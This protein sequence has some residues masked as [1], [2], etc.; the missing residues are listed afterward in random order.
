MAIAKTQK[1]EIITIHRTEIKN[2]EY[3]P[4]FIT[5]EAEKRLKQGLKKFGLATTL[6]WNKRTG[7][8]VSGHQRLAQMDLIEGTQ[9]YELTVSCVDLSK[10][11]MALNVQMNNTSMMGEFDIDALEE[12]VNAGADLLDFGFSESDI[13]IMF[14]DSEL[15]EK[16]QDSS[17]VSEAKADLQE[18]KKN[19]KEYAERMKKENDCSYYFMVVC[20]N[21]DEKEELFKKMGV[22]FS[23]EF[24]SAELLKRL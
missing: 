14:G 9:D 11:E 15:A 22:P 1:F 5:K 4:R 23:E 7:N 19:R 21:S 8:L 2:A 17:E 20:A 12:M 3:N 18:I 10:D 13:D 24:I 6:T 16:Y